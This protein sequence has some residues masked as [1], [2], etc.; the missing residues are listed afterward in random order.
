MRRI[1]TGDVFKVARL[2]KIGGIMGAVKT[3]YMA[4]KEKD[5]DAEKIGIN[6]VMDAISA[7]TDP[8]IENQF[9]DLLSGICEK[10]PEDVRNQPLETTVADLKRICE[11]NDVANFL[12]SASR[13]GGIMKG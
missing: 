7:C 13:L 2:M 11:E 4:G 9:Y 10:K 8:E 6:V 12:K 1:N 5:A 3:A